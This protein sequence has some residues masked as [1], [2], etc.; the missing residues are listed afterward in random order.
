MPEGSRMDELNDL[1]EALLRKGDAP[2]REQTADTEVS[3]LLEIGSSLREL[4]RESFK[5]RLK[6]DLERSLG[7]ASQ[8][9]SQAERA[10]AIRQSA[11]PRLRIRN[12]AA[13]IEFYRKAFGAREVFRFEDNT[14]IA[15]AVIAIGNS[16]IAVADENVDWGGLSPETLGGSPVS[17]H[18]DVE[19]VDAAVAQAVAA[20]ARITQPVRDQFYGERSGTVADPYGYEWGISTHREDLS[21][22]EMHRR[23]EEMEK[24]RQAARTA[25]SFIPEGFHTAT[26]YL[27]VDNVPAMNE[28]LNKVFGAEETFR[29]V[30]SAGGY[31]TE[32]RIRDSRLMVGGGAPDLSW[33]GET[34]P[35]AFHVY[36]EDTD[37]VYRKAL[38]AGATSIA[39]PTDQSYGERSAS[40]K[41]QFG[42]NWYIATYQGGSFIPQGFRTVTPSLHPLRA[43][44]MI[45]F[46]KRAFGA[47]NVQR[48][49]TPQGVV[50]HATVTIGDSLIE[51]GEAHGP[52]QPMPT[53]F[54]LYVPDVDSTYHRALQ[55]GAVSMSEPTDQPYG[56]RTAG[57]KDVFGNQWY[58]ATHI[59]DVEHP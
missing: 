34:F 36:V 8:A 6:A 38:E 54:Y 48:Y 15:H 7:M 55:A 3:A 25:P 23:L 12:A 24:G 5:A 1:L 4:P 13:A 41:D 45:D 53:H 33:R 26:T 42:N 29:A 40:V 57:V 43:D 37:A 17:L 30:G 58:I 39:P 50:L 11:M 32:I 49:A 51:M 59:R 19:D 46:L 9:T 47:G 27:I 52:Y 44:P 10:P 21:L 20:G 22:D 2:R 28:F 35:S 56:D 16:E 14:Q 18:L 31:H